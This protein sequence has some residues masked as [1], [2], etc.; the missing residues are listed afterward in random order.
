M[1]PNNCNVR[2]TISRSKTVGRGL[3]ERIETFLSPG[4]YI[5]VV[6][7]YQGDEGAF[8]LSL[9]CGTDCTDI[10]DRYSCFLFYPRPDRPNHYQFNI[11][12][13]QFTEFSSNATEVIWAF[14]GVEQALDQR[15]DLDVSPWLNREVEICVTWTVPG[16]ASSEVPEDICYTY[17]KRVR[18]PNDP[19]TCDDVCFFP[20]EGDRSNYNFYSDDDVLSWVL[21]D[22]FNY[23][24]YSAEHTFD[25]DP[26][27][28]SYTHLT[29]PTNREV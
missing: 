22:E 1:I 11:E 13:S 2:Q 4:S 5:I 17:C 14:D 12:E 25:Y 10:S 27:P 8:N 20:T 23:I 26:N 21:H 18:F 3:D 6:E 15:S 9:N 24:E 16:D 19:Y 7:G 29:L 28:V